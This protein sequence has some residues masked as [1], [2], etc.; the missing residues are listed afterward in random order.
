MLKLI[1]VSDQSELTISQPCWTMVM[2]LASDREWIPAGIMPFCVGEIGSREDTLSLAAELEKAL[3]TIP[4]EDSGKPVAFL[5]VE[6]FF[7]GRSKPVLVE[8]VAFLQ[9]GPFVIW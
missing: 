9:K 7:S 5:S 6:E 2:L 8:L 1:S 4:D 3:S